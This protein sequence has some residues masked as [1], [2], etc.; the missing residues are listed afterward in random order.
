MLLDL[1][2]ALFVDLGCKIFRVPSS[3]VERKLDRE[4][5][6]LLEARDL[7]LH[8][9]NVT[10]YSIV[11]GPTFRHHHDQSRARHELA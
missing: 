11:G 3:P 8:D 2:D 6:A 4:R 10:F 9:S 5:A 1:L 7:A